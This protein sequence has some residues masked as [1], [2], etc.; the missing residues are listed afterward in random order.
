MRR[1]RPFLLALAL[2]PALGACRAPVDG[3][4]PEDGSLIYF[5]AP[6][7][8]AWG[9]DRIQASV[10]HLGLPENASLQASAEAVVERLLAG[11]A[12]GE[13]TSPLPDGVSLLSLDVRDGRAYVDLS[14]G[15]TRLSGVDLAL[16]DYCFTLS[17][18]GLDGINEVSITA[19]GRTLGQQPKQVFCERDVLLASMDGVVQTAEATLYFLNSENALVGER[20]ILEIYEGQTLAENLVAALLEGP[21]SQ[22]LSP[23]IPEGFQINL[24]R[25]ENGICYVNI[26]AASLDLLPP[27]EARQR[28]ILWSLADSLY[29]L[30]SVDELRLLA[31]GKELTQFGSVPVQEAAVKPKG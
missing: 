24:V 19:Q 16:A 23:V 31:D 8:K 27:D 2:L 14:D 5:L 30:A 20:R 15:V 26:A 1:I 13:L 12:D 25:V 4:E 7:A 18:A 29:S 22:D 17:L 6:E 10:E 11:P 9:G 28:M 3:R 21:Q